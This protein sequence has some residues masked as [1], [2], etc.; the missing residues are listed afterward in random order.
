MARHVFSVLCRRAETGQNGNVSLIDVIEGLL[1]EQHIPDHEIGKGRIALEMVL[2]TLWT[3][4]QADAP[5]L[6]RERVVLFGPGRRQLQ[7]EEFAID[8]QS[9]A[10]YRAQVRSSYLPFGGLG[11]Y[12]FEV[13]VI[14]ESG[15]AIVVARVPFG[16]EL[17]PPPGGI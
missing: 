11:T 13:A 8:L 7:S 9:S 1:T 10:R 14:D 17:R 16:F 15:V 3:R 6:V 4:D 2:V 5:E 12:E